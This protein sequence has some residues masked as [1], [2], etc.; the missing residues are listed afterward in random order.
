MHTQSVV[1]TLC[2]D[3]VGLLWIG[4]PQSVISPASPILRC[5][6]NCCFIWVCSFTAPRQKNSRSHLIHS[7]YHSYHPQGPSFA[8]YQCAPATHQSAPATSHCTHFLLRPATSYTLPFF[9]QPQTLT[10]FQSTASDPYARH[11]RN[12]SKLS[13]R[14]FYSSS[15]SHQSCA[16][17]S[18][19]I[20][21]KSW[22]LPIYSVNTSFKYRL[23]RV[24]HPPSY[25]MFLLHASSL[26]LTPFHRTPSSHPNL[27]Y[28]H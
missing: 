9:P 16:S 21:H 11:G 8:L 10:L 2:I 3:V 1:E 15:L 24:S 26:V 17:L 7:H 23:A 20:I 25:L 19:S 28:W 13:N 22:L 18:Q 12:T 27:H 4:L 14:L 5:S 6:N